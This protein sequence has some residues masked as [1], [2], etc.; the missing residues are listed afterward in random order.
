MIKMVSQPH[1]KNGKPLKPKDLKKG[2]RKS[3]LVGTAHG[4]NQAVTE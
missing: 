4:S 1:F 3:V 2:P